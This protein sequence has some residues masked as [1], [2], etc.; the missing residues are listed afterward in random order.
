[1]YIDS[2]KCAI[3]GKT[4]TRCLLR[5]SNPEKGK[6]KHRTLV[7]L[8]KAPENVSVKIGSAFGTVYA[9]ATIAR[10]LK[11]TESLGKPS[12]RVTRT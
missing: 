11:I 4:Y 7:S 5:E 9:L 2:A 6:V 8:S 12:M 1:M 3:R 10:R